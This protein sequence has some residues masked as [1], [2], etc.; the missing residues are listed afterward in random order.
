MA[1][2]K[3]A[4][5]E[6]AEGAKAPAQKS[7]AES[8]GTGPQGTP[9]PVVPPPSPAQT[10]AGGETPPGTSKVA[11]PAITGGTSPGAAAK[12]PAVTPPKPATAA[13][14]P[15]APPKAPVKPDPWS[16]PL[17][18]ELQKKFPGAISEAVI[19][20]SQPSLNIGKE[21]L[22]AICRFLKESCRWGVYAAH[23]R[24]RGRLSQAGKAF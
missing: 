5:P 21:H 22:V 23:G 8:G 17:L 2:E 20:R 12:P 24:N 19:F 9:T 13:P 3:K 1:D 15:A 14:K 4:P 11:A 6:A 18:D 16:S 10:G 7:A